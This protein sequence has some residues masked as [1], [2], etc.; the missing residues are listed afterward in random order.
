MRNGRNGEVD[1]L[2]REAA[3]TLDMGKRLE[4]YR[5]IE[6]IMFGESGIMPLVPFTCP[7]TWF[8]C[9]IG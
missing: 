4:L 5:Q 6:N 1:T 8:W 2:I 9:R 3:N 7:P